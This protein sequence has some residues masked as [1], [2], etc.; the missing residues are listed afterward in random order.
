MALTELSLAVAGQACT[1][2]NNNLI[3]SG[4]IAGDIFNSYALADVQVLDLRSVE[5]SARQ[6]QLH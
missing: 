2:W 5:S 6:M 3:V 1:L 4:G